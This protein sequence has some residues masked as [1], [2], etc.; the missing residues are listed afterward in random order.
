MKNKKDRIFVIKSI[1]YSEADKIITVFGRNRGKFTMI[2][3]GVRK[4]NSKNRGN[5]QTFSVADISYFE[6][7]GMP[8]LLETAQVATLDYTDIDSNSAQRVL[9]MLNKLT[10]DDVPNEK[11]FDALES[12]VLRG[13]TIENVNK[14]RTVFLLVEGILGDL[15]M[16]HICLSQDN[17]YIDKHNLESICENCIL[18]GN[19]NRERYILGNKEI[20]SNK[21]YT[22]ILDKYIKKAIEE[23]T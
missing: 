9:Q 13:L 5:I 22:V 14:L 17:L 12:I 10:V 4:M 11:V 20:Y 19:L 2:A 18:N 21:E 3:K 1:N 23:T 7:N 15:S 16:C 6:G 8:L